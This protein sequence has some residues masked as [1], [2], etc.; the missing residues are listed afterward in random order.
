MM[1][2]F[3]RAF[4]ALLLLPLVAA[5]PAARP[6]QVNVRVDGKCKTRYVDVQ[7]VDTS[8]PLLIELQA[9]HRDAAGIEV[10]AKLKGFRRSKKTGSPGPVESQGALVRDANNRR[11]LLAPLLPFTICLATTH[12][13]PSL[14]YPCV[15]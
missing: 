10:G 15:R 6:G 3:G 7:I 5:L 11:P 13:H 12:H 9:H 1:G 2:G 14:A 4:G 8:S